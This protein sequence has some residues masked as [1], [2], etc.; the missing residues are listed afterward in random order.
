MPAD[1][2]T[3]FPLSVLTPV[4]AKFVPPEGAFTPE[5]QW[6]HKYGVYTI[7]QR[8]CARVGE[9]LLTRRPDADGTRLM[10]AY[11]KAAPGGANRLTADIRC[12]ADALASPM[13]WELAGSTAFSDGKQVPSTAFR[14]SAAVHGSGIELRDGVKRRALQVGP[15]FTLNWCLFDA[16]QRLPAEGMKPVQF[17]LLD[18]FDQ[19]KPGQTLAP[20]GQ[21]TF[22]F[23]GSRV[24]R[25][26]LV[27]LERGTIHRPVLER[28]G[29]Q[30]VVLRQYSQTGR[31][32]VPWVYYVDETGRLLFAV[33]GIEAY[34]WEEKT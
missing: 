12:R 23:G 24:V 5:G 14:Q 7:G 3:V 29:G 16:V 17:T 15:P 4:L 2:R 9:V 34:V 22:A 18:D 20:H 13:S 19:V 8:G 28:E 10:L 1:P 6:T 27:K 21:V 25:H 26:R 32:V 30:N 33:G 31:G 11:D